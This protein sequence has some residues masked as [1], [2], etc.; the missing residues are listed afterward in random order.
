MVALFSLFFFLR[1]LPRHCLSSIFIRLCVYVFFNLLRAFLGCRAHRLNNIDV[2]SVQH[3]KYPWNMTAKN[4]VYYGNKLNM[5]NISSD[6]FAHQFICDFE[7]MVCNLKHLSVRLC[8]L[9]TRAATNSTIIII[10]IWLRWWQCSKAMSHIRTP[11]NPAG[12][13]TYKTACHRHFAIEM[14]PNETK[15]SNAKKHFK[16]LSQNTWHEIQLRV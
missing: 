4:A 11:F 12:S 13:V 16:Y 1:W 8:P 2:A 10:I 6:S 9:A 5:P 3:V 14:K 7:W 15:W